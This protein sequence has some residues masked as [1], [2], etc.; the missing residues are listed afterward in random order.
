MHSKV[1]RLLGITCSLLISTIWAQQAKK[2]WK[3][4]A[5]F[6]LYD[7]STKE[8]TPA[9][10]IELLE[11]W[12]AK[13]PDSQFKQ[14]RL[15]LYINT[16]A[17]MG[18]FPELINSAKEILQ[19][20]P[21]DLTALYWITS[22][23]PK[24]N[25]TSVD[26]L[27]TGEKAASALLSNLD[28]IFADDKRPQNTTP[29]AWKKAR[30]DMEVLGLK[31]QGWVAMQRKQ[32]EQAE[33][34]FVQLLDKNPSDGEIS[35]WMYT[36]TRSNADRQSEALFHLARAASL[37]QD[38]GGLPDA[39]RKQVDDFFVK[40]YNR[41]HGQDEDAL[42]ELRKLAL[43][44][45]RPER[46]FKIKTQT[47]IAVEKENEF[48]QKNPQLAF[49]MG[50]KKEL[51]G[52]EGEKFFEERVKG[53]ALPGKIEGTEFTKLRGR[54]VSHKPA[55][56]PK[57]LLVAMDTENPNS[58]AEVTLKFETA[59][60]GKAEPGIDIDFEGAPSA[61]TKEPFMLTFDVEKNGFAGWPVQAPAPA[62]KATGVKKAAPK[63]K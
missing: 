55:A 47:E 53:A 29:D 37:T 50:I 15:T 58:P 27:A 38:K 14:E 54:L 4:R 18:K 42:K 49:W 33:K 3:D 21:R 8:A 24:L 46:S 61:F 48:R 13:Y 34:L 57:E 11:S 52:P 6:D 31:T 19:L 30:H 10:R 22:L 59:L 16:Y 32:N 51:T 35:Y 56:N 23:T 44:G 9:K 40:A 1:A 28:T 60:R 62:K 20:D 63:K 2:E 39:T 17:Q 12:K 7:S 45:A 43:S 41:Y 25:N 26:F 5:E 36:V